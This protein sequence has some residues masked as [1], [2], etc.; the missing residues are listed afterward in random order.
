MLSA[1]DI[2]PADGKVIS[3]DDFFLN[4]S[5]LTGESLPVEKFAA[6]DNVIFSGTNVISGYSQFLVTTI[7]LETEFGKIAQKIA[8]PEVENALKK[9]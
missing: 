4:E 5:S 6:E 7:G 2:V 3:A 1:G 8:K 9:A